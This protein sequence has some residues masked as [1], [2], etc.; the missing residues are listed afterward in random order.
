MA[1]QIG[2]VVDQGDGAI[3]SKIRQKTT[4][5]QRD[6]S[7]YARMSKMNGG[8]SINQMALILLKFETKKN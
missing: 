2:R 6:T 1:K 5:L 3:L 4:P 7:R 8:F